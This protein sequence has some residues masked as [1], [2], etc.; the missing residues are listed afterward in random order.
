[1]KKAS[2][3][4]KAEKLI[5]KGKKRLA[6]EPKYYMDAIKMTAR[7]IFCSLLDEFRPY[8]DNYRD[9]HLLLRE[10]TRSHG[11]VEYH[12]GAVTIELHPDRNYQ[13]RRRKAVI[14]FLEDVSKKINEAH[15]GKIPVNIT[16]SSRTLSGYPPKKESV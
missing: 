5:A 8:P 13:P 6:Y 11:Y 12:D 10:L 3:V 16:L 7:N 14:R 9:D 15:P 2:K 4:D 1:M